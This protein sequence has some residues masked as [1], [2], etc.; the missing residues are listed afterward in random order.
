[1][2]CWRSSVSTMMLALG[3][4]RDKE[5]SSNRPKAAKGNWMNWVIPSMTY[6]KELWGL[7]AKWFFLW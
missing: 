7:A 2:K 5:L 4:P 6:V 1:M 3:A